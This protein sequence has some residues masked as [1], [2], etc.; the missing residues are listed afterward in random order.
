MKNELDCLCLRFELTSRETRPTGHPEGS[1]TD[2]IPLHKSV[3]FLCRV[4]GMQ[5]RERMGG[6]TIEQSI[7]IA[8]VG[9]SSGSK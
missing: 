2:C 4:G 7:V 3:E 8:T 1:R 6:V 9:G 5:K